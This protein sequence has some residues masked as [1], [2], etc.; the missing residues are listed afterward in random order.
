MSNKTLFL[1]AIIVLIILASIP[2][3]FVLYTQ[4]TNAFSLGFFAEAIDLSVVEYWFKLVNDNSIVYIIIPFFIVELIRYAVLK[5]MS[6]NLIG[7]SIAN[8]ISLYA[9]LAIELI[10]AILFLYQLYFWV[11]EK[12]SIAQL[13]LNYITIIICILLADFAYYWDHRLMHRIGLGWATHTVHH[14]SPH[15]NMSVAYRFGPL[16]ALF[17]VLFSL[18][19]VILGFNPWLLLAAEVFVQTYQA[20]LHTEMIP[21]LPKPIEAIM[22]TPSHHRVHHGVNKQYWDKNYAG[23]LIIWDRMFGTFEEEVEEVR[24][25]VSEPI[26]SVNPIIVFFHG[27]S[28]FYKQLKSV[29]GLKN[30]LLLFVKPPGWI[31]DEN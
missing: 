11:Y 7:D 19:I 24:Y 10:L 18:P 5:R 9:F 25:G 31:P 4:T 28:R 16:D 3:I 12:M 6:W 21:K 15:F 20:I 27:F 1:R 13:P 29:K 23:I 30:K 14:S 8:I 17:P 22:N 2:H 26:N